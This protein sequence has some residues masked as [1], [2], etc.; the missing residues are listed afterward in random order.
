M[1][2]L[3]ICS[4]T[5]YLI[6]LLSYRF[7]ANNVEPAQIPTHNITGIV[8]KSLQLKLRRAGVVTG[9]E[10]LK[11][12][13]RAFRRYD[14]NYRFVGEIFL[15][16][17]L[18]EQGLIEQGKNFEEINRGTFYQRAAKMDNVQDPEVSLFSDK[19]CYEF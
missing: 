16:E 14:D 17:T 5:S 8:A 11:I 1:S 19:F 18:F 9:V 12:L 7:I 10:G 4:L 2:F 13:W 15:G 6:F 3:K